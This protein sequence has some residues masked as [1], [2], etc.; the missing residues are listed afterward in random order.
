MQFREDEYYEVALER[1]RQ[2]R[3]LHD[4][5][6]NYA[7]SMYCSGLAVECLLRA[8]R[9]QFDASFEGRHNLGELLKASRVLQ[10]NDELMRR[11]GRR[12]DEITGY[13]R[14][15]KAAMNEVIALWHNNLRYASGARLKAFLRSSDRLQ[16]IRGDALKRNSADLLG[17]AQTI[18]DR[19]VA[20]WM[21]RK[22]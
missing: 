17:A 3:K 12:E 7:L 9:W 18:V 13:G 11:K 5:G 20:L 2:A 4:Q 15:L 19:G 1:I 14:Q 10:I 22:R 8:F 16:G 21:S 6:G